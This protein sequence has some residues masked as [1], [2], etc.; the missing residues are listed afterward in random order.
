M[1]A[2]AAVA[3][4]QI[5]FSL[6]QIENHFPD[7]IPDHYVLLD[8]DSMVSIFCNSNLLT[9]I[10][11]APEPLI[12]ENNGGGHQVPTQMGTITNFGTVWYNPESIT[13]ILFLAQVRKVC[14]ITMDTAVQPEFHM[15]TID[16][17]G[18][19]VFVEQESGLYLHDTSLGATTNTVAKTTNSPIIGYLYLQLNRKM[20]CP[21]PFSTSWACRF[22]CPLPATYISFPVAQ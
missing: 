13:N 15:H 17:S 20:G 21:G 3:F 12:L 5:G 16:G 10:H 19:T 8:S 7:G 14:R 22:F 4:T 1:D 6:A 11:D 9:D 2:V 18:Y